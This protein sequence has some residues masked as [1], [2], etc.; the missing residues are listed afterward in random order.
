MVR[1]IDNEASNINYV[2]SNLMPANTAIE[3]WQKQ[4]TIITNPS[5]T[6]PGQGG[7]P[8]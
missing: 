4:S 5:T 7:Q 8:Q 6:E 3:F 2:P 1:T